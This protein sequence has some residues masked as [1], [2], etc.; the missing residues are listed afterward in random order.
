MSKTNSEG[1]YE[2][3]ER[4][5]EMQLMM[6]FYMSKCSVLV[7]TIVYIFSFKKM[8]KGLQYI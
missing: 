3:L 2:T 8:Q 4:T 7:Q 5:G 1:M 6:K